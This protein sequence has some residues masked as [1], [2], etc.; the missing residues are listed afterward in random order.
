MKASET[1]R[2]FTRV[3]LLQRIRDNYATLHTQSLE[4]SVD[5]ADD[6]MAR[7]GA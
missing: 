4:D 5:F 6:V 7:I 2:A 3:G 1:M